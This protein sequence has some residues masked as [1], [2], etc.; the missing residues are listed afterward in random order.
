MEN[1]QPI[2]DAHPQQKKIKKRFS[3]S[4]VKRPKSNR[5]T[6]KSAKGGGKS[7]P[8]H[9]KY[10]GNARMQTANAFRG[11]RNSNI[12]EEYIYQKTPEKNQDYLSKVQSLIK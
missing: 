5:S 4:G 9:I 1:F 3:R 11:E 8:D 2:E 12:H 7:I 6:S 10:L